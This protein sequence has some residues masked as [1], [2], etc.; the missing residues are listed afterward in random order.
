MHRH[1]GFQLLHPTRAICPCRFSYFVSYISSVSHVTTAKHPKLTVVSCPRNTLPC[2]PGKLERV[3]KQ[4][5]RTQYCAREKSAGDHSG[6]HSRK[7]QRVETTLI[8]LSGWVREDVSTSM[9]RRATFSCPL[10][11]RKTSFSLF[12]FRLEDEWKLVQFVP[13]ETLFSH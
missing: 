10:A 11:G 3:C 1:F 13:D 4:Q 7:L 8:C 12:L 5:Y 2:R 6:E 9:H